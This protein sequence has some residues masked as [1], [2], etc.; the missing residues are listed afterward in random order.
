M[1]SQFKYKLAFIAQK[2]MNFRF[3]FLSFLVLQAAVAYAENPLPKATWYRYYDSKGVANISTN[4]TP[5]HI[6]HGYE[7][8]DQNMQVIRR[9]RA[10]NTEADIKQ[11]PQRAAHA[12]QQATDLKLKKAYGNSQV[13]LAKRND[14]L[15]NI[16]KQ[17]AFQQDQLKQ[18]QTDRIYFKRQQIEHLRKAENIPVSLKTTIENNQKNIEAKRTM[19]QSLQINY[20]KTQAEYDNIIAR[21]KALE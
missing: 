8:L 1:Q 13:A 15:G 16:K 10:Y 20:R 4:V 5:N 21:L 7:A 11:A 6:R 3:I 14:A 9:N 18:L 12:K 2:K 19:I 17:I